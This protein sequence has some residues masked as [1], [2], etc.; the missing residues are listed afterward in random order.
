MSNHDPSIPPTSKNTKT[1]QQVRQQQRSDAERTVKLKTTPATVARSPAAPS[2]FKAPVPAPKAE[3]AIPDD[4]SY[5]ERYLD[6]V[7]PSSLVGR[8]IKFNGKEGQFVTADD[9][10]PIPEGAE[11]VAIADMTLIGW[12]KFN[13]ED[14]PP[15]RHQ[16]LLYDNYIMPSRESLGDL[17]PT[18]WELGLDGQPQDPWAHQ[19][20]L[21]LQHCDTR[22]MFTFSTQSKTGRRAVG[23]LLK[24]YERMQRSGSSEY[25]VVRLKPGGYPHRDERIGWV[26]VP[27]F[28]A[29][30][31]APRESAIRPD[32]SPSADLDDAIPDFG[33]KS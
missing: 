23:N 9:G 19:M 17:D 24:H 7:A 14:A 33:D 6:E 5:R 21:V 12:I 20:C 18:R 29:V 3:V 1:P 16:G 25:P 15:D 31:R 10:E 13:G 26:A 4:R 2:N 30:G 28:V 8:L 22:E 32:T 27:V 11:F